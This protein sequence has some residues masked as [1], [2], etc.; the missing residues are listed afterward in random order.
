M[1]LESKR[2]LIEE[3]SSQEMFRKISN[4]YDKIESAK[5]IIEEKR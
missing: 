4:Q 2:N 5:Q 1:D 3:F